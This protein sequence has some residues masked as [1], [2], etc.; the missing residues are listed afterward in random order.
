MYCSG[1]NNIDFY[2][3]ICV[4]I[5]FPIQ[6]VTGAYVPSS[7]SILCRD[8]ETK[9]SWNTYKF[10]TVTVVVLHCL[11]EKSKELLNQDITSHFQ[12]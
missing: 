11:I 3:Y 7:G 2:K 9:V 1:P 12:N 5:P 8:G 6:G 10:I 4:Y